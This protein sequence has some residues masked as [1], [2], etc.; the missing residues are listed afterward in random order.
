MYRTGTMVQWYYPWKILHQLNYSDNIG[1]TK[2]W[3]INWK[4][5]VQKLF[6]DNSILASTQNVIDNRNILSR[7]FLGEYN[8]NRNS[9]V[10]Y[11]CI[12]L[13]SRAL[14]AEEIAHNYAIDKARFNLTTPTI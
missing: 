7:W 12:R 1:I 5:S 3:S 4:P 8:G 11:Y 6:C 9:K 10:D 14:T 2:S 13:Y